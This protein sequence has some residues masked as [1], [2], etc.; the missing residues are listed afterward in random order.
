[1]RRYEREAKQRE[2][3]EQKE[4]W[5]FELG[6]TKSNKRERRRMQNRLAQR[7]FRARSKIRNKEVGPAQSRGCISAPSLPIRLRLNSYI[8]L[9]VA[10]HMSHLEA[11]TEAQAERLGT[12]TELVDRLQ[13]ENTSLKQARWSSAFG[14]FTGYD[15]H[16]GSETNSSTAQVSPNSTLVD[17]P[18]AGKAGRQ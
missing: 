1:M 10:H 9:L 5:E 13:R 14:E 15:Q 17:G 18:E 2:V 4:I 3:E 8:S 7:A 12:L 11:L 16:A 6:R